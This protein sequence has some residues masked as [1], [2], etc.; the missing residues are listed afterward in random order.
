M[1][2]RFALAALFAAAGLVIASSSSSQQRTL[3]PDLAKLAGGKGLDVFNRTV[4]SVKDETKAGLHLSEAPDNGVA[5]L[6]GI[7]LGNGTIELDIRG[8]DV[9]QQSFVGVAFHGV[10]DTTYDAV[11]FRPFN[12][13]TDDQARRKRAV[14][15][16]SHPTYPWQKLRAEHPGEY[17]QPVSPAPDPNAWFH[18][19]VVVASPKV[20]VF[21]ADA[22]QP[23]L[24][25]TQLSERHTGRVGLWVGNNSGGDFANLK[26]VPKQ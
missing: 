21:V 7:E 25:V 26:I 18:V 14:Q 23:S 6:Q 24:V 19:R 13:K 1:D 9:Q 5:Y 22:T 8:R 12:F 11:Y 17:E 16:I 2:R 4:S 15:Y 10:D 20:S 3:E